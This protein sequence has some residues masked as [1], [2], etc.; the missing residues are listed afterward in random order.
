MQ[1][2]AVLAHD[3]QGATHRLRFV[4]TVRF[5]M[6]NAPDGGVG[7]GMQRVSHRKKWI[8]IARSKSKAGLRRLFNHP[9]GGP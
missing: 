4:S 6:F 5:T 8:L 1:N 3:R 9:D 7:C 2:H